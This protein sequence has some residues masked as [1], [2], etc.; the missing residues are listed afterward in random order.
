MDL[1][2]SL[3]TLPPEAVD[4]LRFY[5][6]IDGESAHAD[7]IVDGAGLSERGFGK[8]I[9]RLV[10]KNY[11]A[12][13]SDQVYRLTDAGKRVVEELKSYDGDAPQSQSR[14]REP[15]FLRRRVVL[16]TPRILT[17]DM[18]VEV[19]LG[20]ED[21]DDDEALNE[22]VTML[23]RLS[24]VNG[25]PRRPKESS[26][27]LGNRKLQQA[28][29]I[30]AGHFT[31]ARVRVEVCQFHDDGDDFDFCGGLYVDLPVSLDA[32]VDAKVAHGVD[33][34]LKEA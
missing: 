13:S 2:Y 26:F 5:A 6:G 23:V 31:R 3:Q 24:M 29:E 11:V 30:N 12:M 32:S 9:R 8:G 1:P 17:A 28:F 33:V 10:T 25:E 34:I 20:F 21:A 19:V 18:P 16:V 15:L 4:I 7:S 27:T 22:P 14:R